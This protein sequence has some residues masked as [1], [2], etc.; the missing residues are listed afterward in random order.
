M[1]F[2]AKSKSAS[3][4]NRSTGMNKKTLHEIASMLEGEAC[5]LRI[6]AEDGVA[7]RHKRILGRS[8]SSIESAAYT[9]RLLLSEN[10][11]NENLADALGLQTIG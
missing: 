4:V 5:D 9:I 7:G 3:A 6:L 10:S 1:I 11:E 8:A 2:A